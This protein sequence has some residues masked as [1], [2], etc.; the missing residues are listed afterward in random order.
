M[1]KNTIYIYIYSKDIRARHLREIT[2][3]AVS[4]I[5]ITH[6]EKT[7]PDVFR[8]AHARD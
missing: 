8:Y 2:A 7:C 6:D 4:C 3:L 5:A 1:A